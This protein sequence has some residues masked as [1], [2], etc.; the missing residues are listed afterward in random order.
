MSKSLEEIKDKSFIGDQN[1][2]KSAHFYNFVAGLLS[3]I[4]LFFLVPSPCCPVRS[5]PRTAPSLGGVGTTTS[6]I[7]HAVDWTPDC[8][9]HADWLWLVD[10]RKRTVEWASLVARRGV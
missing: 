3:K 4:M 8:G 9:L 10:S 6:R 1:N 2:T 5:G 7:K